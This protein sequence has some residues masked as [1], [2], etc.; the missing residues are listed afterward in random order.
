MYIWVSSSVD[1][2]IHASPP[3]TAKHISWQ[4]EMLEA[5]AAGGREAGAMNTLIEEEENIDW[6]WSHDMNNRI[7]FS[8]SPNRRLNMEL[9]VKFR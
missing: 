4:N 8:K 1:Y 6:M 7:T 3:L 9:F 5:Y 2:P